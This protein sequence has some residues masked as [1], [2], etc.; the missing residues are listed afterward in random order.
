MDVVSTLAEIETAPINR[1]RSLYVVANQSCQRA[2]IRMPLLQFAGF[3][4]H[5][6]I[7]IQRLPASV[8]VDGLGPDLPYFFI[9]KVDR[10]I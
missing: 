3:S 7:E 9:R 4:L 8:Y 1:Q 10:W 2:L 6:V 5:T